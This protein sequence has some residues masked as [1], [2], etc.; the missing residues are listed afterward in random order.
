MMLFFFCNSHNHLHLL[1]MFSSI[2]LEVYISLPS[3]PACNLNCFT[4]SFTIL[5]Q[6][7]SIPLPLL[8]YCCFSHDFH[9]CREHI[10]VAAPFTW[11][12]KVRKNFYFYLN[13]SHSHCSLFLCMD[14]SFCLLSYF[15]IWRISFNILFRV[16]LLVAKSLNF[17]LRNLSF[18]FMEDISAG[19]RVI[20]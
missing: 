3:L 16:E 4:C 8:S 14:L 7:I 19:Y 2:C 18:S 1:F 6:Y 17:C 13:L 12:F 5:Q 15:F 9:I 20:D 11:N 10:Y